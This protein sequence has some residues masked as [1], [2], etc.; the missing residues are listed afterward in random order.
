MT[1]TDL[2]NAVATVAGITKV[3]SADAV[4]G[5]F[6]AIGEALKKGESITVSG[7]GTF[8]TVKRKARKGK[9]PQTGQPLD[10]P[11]RTAVKFSVG[12]KLK[13]SMG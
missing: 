10:I 3:K 6:Q 4:D 2:I 1:K 11:A 13:E 9:N 5:V 12:K 8:S 7:F